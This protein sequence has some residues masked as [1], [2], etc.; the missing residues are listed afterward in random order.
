MLLVIV[1]RLGAVAAKV[2]V[3]GQLHGFSVP[4]GEW[5]GGKSISA[6]F[7]RLISWSPTHFAKYAK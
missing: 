6:F 2:Q 5:N 3:S 7:A 4:F 1:E